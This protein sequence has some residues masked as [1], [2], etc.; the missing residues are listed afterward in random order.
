MNNALSQ[1]FSMSVPDEMI[2]Y[3]LTGGTPRDVW[4]WTVYIVAKTCVTWMHANHITPT[5][6]NTK[7]LIRYALEEEDI[8]SD[9]F[10]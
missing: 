3:I 9:G 4:E 7:D 1:N 8:N 2:E 6:A 10:F 5:H